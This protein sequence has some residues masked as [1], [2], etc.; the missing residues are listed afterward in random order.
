MK[1]IVSGALA[2]LPSVGTSFTKVYAVLVTNS[3][4]VGRFI[5]CSHINV[6]GEEGRSGRGGV[7]LF[8]FYCNL[9]SGQYCLMKKRGYK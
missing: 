8:R 9:F 4:M 6:V 1:E 7:N 5:D 2:I 3:L